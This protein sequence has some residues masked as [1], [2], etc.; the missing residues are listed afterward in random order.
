MARYR[1]KTDIMFAGVLRR[2]GDEFEYDGKGHGEPDY[3]MELV[4]DDKSEKTERKPV[5]TSTGE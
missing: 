2:A 5:K 4:E 3:N 1:A